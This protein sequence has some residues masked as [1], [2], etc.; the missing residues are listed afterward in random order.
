MRALVRVVCARLCKSGGC[1]EERALRLQQSL[2]QYASDKSRPYHVTLWH[3][4]RDASHHLG[5]LRALEKEKKAVR[6]RPEFFAMDECVAAVLVSFV[7]S[8]GEA[9]GGRG[10]G[11][12]IVCFNSHPHVTVWVAKKGLA[13]LSNALLARLVTPQGRPLT[14]SQTR[15]FGDSA[16]IGDED[17]AVGL[18]LRHPQ[19]PPRSGGVGEGMDG[20]AGGCHALGGGGRC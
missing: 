19:S 10:E 16:G 20:G 1:S 13:Y 18:V 7:E 17:E 15:V 5:A 11:G 9:G 6:L 4:A 14:D 2:Q 8:G 12:R 3:S